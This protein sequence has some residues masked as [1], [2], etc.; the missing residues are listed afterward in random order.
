MEKMSESREEL[1]KR[2]LH[3]QIDK[4]YLRSTI[5]RVC[6][7]RKKLALDQRWMQNME[8]V[9]QFRDFWPRE[10]DTD[11]VVCKTDQA[12]VNT[13][14]DFSC[15]AKAGETRTQ[16]MT[17]RNRNSCGRVSVESQQRLSKEKGRAA[18][19]RFEDDIRDASRSISRISWPASEA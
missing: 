5:D 4:A 10:S 13:R 18:V 11:E 14:T 17:P 12:S 15:G 19:V 3:E 16:E 8:S 6:K 1:V 2:V 7:L 9:S